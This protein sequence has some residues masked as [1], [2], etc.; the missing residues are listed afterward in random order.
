MGSAMVLVA[1]TLLFVIAS[2][3]N[4]A[5]VRRE[6]MCNEYIHSEDSSFSFS[7]LTLLILL[8]LFE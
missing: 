6:G 3:A 8:P 7:P 1:I 2:T 4:S 5:A